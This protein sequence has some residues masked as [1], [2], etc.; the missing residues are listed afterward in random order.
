MVPVGISTVVVSM[1]V[2]AVDFEESSR[3][4]TA[5]ANNAAGKSNVRTTVSAMVARLLVVSLRMALGP[6]AVVQ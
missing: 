5:P 2:L 3:R 6:R 1:T 4:L